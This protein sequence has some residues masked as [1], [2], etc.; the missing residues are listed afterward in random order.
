[1]TVENLIE[2]I[3]ERVGFI[4]SQ[5]GLGAKR[6]EVC[7]DQHKALL[8][9]IATTTG[10]RIAD[11]TKVSQHLAESG[12]WDTGQKEA[13]SACL[14]AA[15]ARSQRLHQ[16]RR[17]MQQNPYLV[18]YFLLGDWSKLVPE[19]DTKDMEQIIA[20]RMHRWGIVCPDAQTLKVASAIVQ[21]A[22]KKRF[23]D[24]DKRAIAKRIQQSVKQLDTD[25]PWPF[26]YVRDYPRSP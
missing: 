11:V 1:M 2:D 23:I 9:T 21:R 13:F 20:I 3:D 12:E 17:S 7:H 16:P 14:R 19:T 15:A 4:H 26:E 18:Y 10:L 25:N 6:D 24:G 22:S 5:V 8:G